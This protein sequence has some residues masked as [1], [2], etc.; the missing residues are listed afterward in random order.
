MRTPPSRWGGTNPVRTPP[1][2]IRCESR[3]NSPFANP[4]RTPPSRWGGT[5]P[6]RIPSRWSRWGGRWHHSRPA[7]RCQVA[8]LPSP[9]SRHL[10]SAESTDPT[11][12]DEP[13]ASSRHHRQQWP[14]ASQRPPA[15]GSS[16]Y[17]RPE[18]S[19]RHR[20]W[21]QAPQRCH[22]PQAPRLPTVVST[23][24]TSACALSPIAEPNPLPRSRKK[25]S[26]KM[27]LS[28]RW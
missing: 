8:T 28:F 2:R 6:V 11:T 14:Q 10:A 12:E 1:S 20:P 19:R 4:V 7:A 3:A 13:Q 25:G 23:D 24:D 17:H 22:R 9:F 5:N 21:P 26:N 16:E 15:T 18:T 27:P